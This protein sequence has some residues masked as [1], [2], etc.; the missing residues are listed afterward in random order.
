M[1]NKIFIAG[2]I[3][4]VIVAGA[5][6]YF[7]VFSAKPVNEDALQTSS[8]TTNQQGSELA[9]GNVYAELKGDAFDEAYIAGMIAHHDGALTMSEQAMATAVR[10]EIRTLASNILQTQGEEI[11]KMITWQKDWGFEA[12]MLGHG[13][14]SG[15]GM[16]M[17][18]DMIEM[19]NKLKGLEG[20]A[21]DQEFLKQ[22]ILHHEQAIEMSR[23]AAT[24]AKR[25]EVKDLAE[26][27][28]RD[29]TAEVKQIKQWQ[30][31]WW[32]Y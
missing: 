11:M 16:D 17:G 26:A 6:W 10:E 24:N 32:G 27:V 31:D 2:I 8:T 7:V 19:Q 15:A 13:G 22:M 29:Q 12:T 30:K 9:S 3:L 1:I 23:Y 18:G 25:Q 21:Y 4:L 28:I 5:V 14:H 20:D